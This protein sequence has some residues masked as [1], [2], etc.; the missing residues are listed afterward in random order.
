MN[1]SEIPDDKKVKIDVTQKSKSKFIFSVNNKKLN[2]KEIISIL[3][4]VPDALHA[5][6]KSNSG[7]IG[8]NIMMWLGIGLSVASS[9]FLLSSIL[10]F[11]YGMAFTN[12]VTTALTISFLAVGISGFL[13]FLPLWIAGTILQGIFRKRKV[14][15]IKL[16]NNT[17]TEKEIPNNVIPISSNN[18]YNRI[19]YINFCVLKI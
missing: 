5:Y 10:S 17:L 8:A 4:D 15:A 11:S 16:Y 19:I 1:S 2:N 3:R 14:D 18:N 6:K 9:P 12:E 7:F 13:V